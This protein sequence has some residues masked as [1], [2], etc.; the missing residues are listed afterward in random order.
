VPFLAYIHAPQP[1]APERRPWK[2]DWGVWRPAMAALFALIGAAQL[3]GAAALVLVLGGFALACRAL[4]SALPYCEGL[5][6]WR[7]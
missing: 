3:D 7:Q 2:P 4:D 5:R 6:E 1:D